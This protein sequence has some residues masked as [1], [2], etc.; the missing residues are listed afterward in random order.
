MSMP[1]TKLCRP[2]KQKTTNGVHDLQR[3]QGSSI[4]PTDPGQMPAAT[5]PWRGETL[6]KN[7]PLPHFPHN[8][9]K[10]LGSIWT[11]GSLISTIPH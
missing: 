1:L 10:T 11:N 3:M 6:Y 7:M 5:P 4:P 9:G 8:L 2:V